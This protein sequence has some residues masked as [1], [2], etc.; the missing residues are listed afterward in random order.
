[1]KASILPLCHWYVH[2]FHLIHENSKLDYSRFMDSS[3]QHKVNFVVV[4]GSI[5]GLCTA[6]CLAK[7]QHNIIVVEK[8]NSDVFQVSLVFYTIYYL[9]MIDYCSHKNF[10]AC[11][12]HQIWQGY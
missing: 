4:G 1:M 7:S 5:G 12:F 3:S 11:A 6:Y 2:P 9:L 10:V 8:Y